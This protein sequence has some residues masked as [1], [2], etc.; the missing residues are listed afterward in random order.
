MGVWPFTI[1]PVLMSMP[2]RPKDWT[3]TAVTSSSTPGRMVGKGLEDGHRVPRSASMEA[4]SQ[5]IAPPPIT[6][7]TP[8]LLEVE[9]L[10]DW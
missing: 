2:R 3:T 1:T 7:A 4:N 5:P 9:D 8:E 10:V 6:A